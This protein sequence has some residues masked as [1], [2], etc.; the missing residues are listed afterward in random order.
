MISIFSEENTNVKK[1][2]F[3]YLKYA[4]MGLAYKGIPGL[5]SHRQAT[6]VVDLG[7]FRR[8][9]ES[10]IKVF[11]YINSVSALSLMIHLINHD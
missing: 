2:F 7:F 10:P 11:S 9:P 4:S 6:I 8:K 1:P 5:E 3:C